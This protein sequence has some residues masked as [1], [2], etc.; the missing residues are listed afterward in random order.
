MLEI[1]DTAGDLRYG[2]RKP[3]VSTVAGK[4]ILFES[5]Y[6]EHEADNGETDKEILRLC[7]RETL[8]SCSQNHS[9]FIYDTF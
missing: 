5:K 6:M 4:A 3:S 9:L 8:S 1:V 7:Q 2:W